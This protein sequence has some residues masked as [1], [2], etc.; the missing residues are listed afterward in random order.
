MLT[1]LTFGP[2]DLVP[3]WSKYK[4]NFKQIS[5]FWKSSLRIKI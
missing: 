4:V 5:G 2:N 3:N 1:M